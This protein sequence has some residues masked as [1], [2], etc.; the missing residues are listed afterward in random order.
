MEDKYFLIKASKDWSDEFHCEFFGVFTET[1]WN[2]L[3]RLVKDC[4][5]EIGTVTVGIGT[6]QY[7]DLNSYSEWTKPLKIIEIQKEQAHF[8]V[9]DFNLSDHT[10]GTGSGWLSRQMFEELLEDYREFGH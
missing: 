1:A 8:L 3:K 4:L 10:F 6:N 9:C 2:S 7:W 5:K